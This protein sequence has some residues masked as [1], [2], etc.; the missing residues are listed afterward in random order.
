VK[1]GFAEDAVPTGTW[2]AGFAIDLDP[3]ARG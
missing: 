3:N 2:P 1:T